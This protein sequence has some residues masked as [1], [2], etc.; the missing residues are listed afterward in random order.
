MRAIEWRERERERKYNNAI[1]TLRS[2]NVKFIL[3]EKA[4]GGH[5]IPKAT[6]NL[7]CDKHN[8]KI[9]RREL[10]LKVNYR[11]NIFSNKL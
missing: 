2:L 1:I 10:P 3:Q 8:N 11:F 7:E 9:N 5:G 4:S 6:T